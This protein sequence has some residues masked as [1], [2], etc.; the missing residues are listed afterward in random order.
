MLLRSGTVVYLSNILTV[1]IKQLVDV[2]DIFKRLYINVFSEGG[3]GEASAQWCWQIIKGRKRVPHKDTKIPNRRSFAELQTLNF[4]NMMIE[5]CKVYLG[6]STNMNKVSVLEQT[7]LPGYLLPIC[8]EA[9]G[10]CRHVQFEDETARKYVTF[11]AA[12]NLYLVV[13][14]LNRETTLIAP[15]K[16]LS[17]TKLLGC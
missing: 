8:Y 16:P 4:S 2:E 3:Q 11:F 9:P 12:G 6:R 13:W 17:Q 14:F 10:S 1:G 5:L 15:D 7:L